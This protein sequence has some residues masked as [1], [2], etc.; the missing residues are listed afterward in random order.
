MNGGSG[1]KPSTNGGNGKTI[2]KRGITVADVLREFRGAKVIAE[3]KPLFCDHCDEV[4]KAHYKRE[5]ESGAPV[6]ELVRLIEK[7]R[8]RITRRT[9]PDGRPDEWA[10]HRCGRR[11]EG[12]HE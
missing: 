5:Y 7:R 11:V 12:T 6:K 10:C 3:N 2:S 8:G 9:W 4:L 1:S